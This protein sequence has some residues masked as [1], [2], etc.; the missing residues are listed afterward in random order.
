MPIDYV[1]GISGGLTRIPGNRL[2]TF[3]LT[4]LPVA[5]IIGRLRLR[6][7]GR[8]RSVWADRKSITHPAAASANHASSIGMTGA[9]ATT[10]YRQV[11]REASA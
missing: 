4:C 9:L 5:D 3:T 8:L 11:E 7:R 2:A 6:F 1:D 10:R